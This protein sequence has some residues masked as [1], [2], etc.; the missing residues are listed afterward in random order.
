MPVLPTY[1]RRQ[2][3]GGGATASY[4]SEGPFTAPGR[5]MQGLGG[6]VAGLGDVIDAKAQ[7]TANSLGD[8]WFSKARAETAKE[9]A[10]IEQTQRMAATDGA[11]DH[12]AGMNEAYQ[13]VRNKWLG[14]APDPRAM[15]MYDEWSQ[16]YGAQVD[17]RALEFRA[18]SALATRGTDLAQTLIAH[19]QT[20]LADP[21][22][23]DETMKRLEDDLAGARQWMT[24]QQ[25]QE[26][27]T[28]AV[29][30][31]NIA[32]SQGD[33]ARDPKA[34]MARMGL[35]QTNIKVAPAQ[36]GGDTQTRGNRAM[37]FF[38]SRGYTK[39]Q[40]AG[41]VGNLVQESGVR[42]DGAVGDNGTAFG[43]AQWRGERFTRLKRFAAAQGKD[44]R[45]FDTQLAYI[46]MELQ[47]HETSAYK[48]LKSAKTVDEATAAFIGYER[49]R[50]WTGANP[51]GGHAYEK[52]L[53]NAA[54][55][56][57]GE[58]SYDMPGAGDFSKDP[59]FAGLDAGE[60]L[61]LYQSAAQASA[62]Q[63]K[64]AQAAL[65]NMQAQTEGA[66]KKGIALGD[67]S[68]TVQSILGSGLPDATQ[69][70]LINSLNEKNKKGLMA[71]DAL[72][73]ASAGGA[74]DRYDTEDKNGVGYAY[75]AVTNGKSIFDQDGA[76]FNALAYLYDR[77]RIVPK[78]AM[79]EIRAGLNS[80]DPKR[81][82]AAGSVAAYLAG[83]DAGA[84]SASEGGS[85]IA[86]AATTYKHLT[87]TLG[88]TADEAG[89]RMVDM[90]DPAK[91]REAK[92]LLESDKVKKKIENINAG[93]IG[94][95]F[96]T[97]YGANPKMGETAQAEAVMVGEYREIF[98][99]A[100]VES[101][102]DL[103]LAEKLADDRFSKLYAV[104]DFSTSGERT[105]TRMPPELAYPPSPVDGTHDYIRQQA[106]EA[107]GEEGIQ[108]SEV[109]LQAF[110]NTEPD[111]R[112]GRPPQ[113]RLYYREEGSD[114]LREFNLPFV[115]DYGLE[116]VRAESDRAQGIITSEQ[117]W[118]INKAAQEAGVERKDALDPVSRG[119]NALGILDPLR[120]AVG[121]ETAGEAKARTD[122]E[123]LREI[124]TK[125][126]RDKMTGAGN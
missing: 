26:F 70:T 44:W 79:N 11:V 52:R 113:Y 85:E 94:D 72:T 65:T 38:M 8:S 102:G 116:Q 56:A 118:E 76:A 89:Q 91:Q 24:P 97:W 98:R 104:T 14:Q 93:K 117:N 23:Y 101:A 34:F 32:K 57:G 120:R 64:A 100:V 29:K 12:Q 27:R 51:R 40:A 59:Q 96:D 28:E 78:A 88:M 122:K 83:V 55:F 53:A 108:A 49:P 109:Y 46:D 25:E 50:G 119:L 20:V 67:P 107:L 9:M 68:V 3:L 2:G 48:A 41:I 10:A 110:G 90:N 35:G 66:F 4:A 17:G 19:A 81:M 95:K 36:I 77:S 60:I 126:L 84:L 63:D 7:K 1:E 61:G 92:A 103:D 22:K 114:A 54:A 69:A 39:E 121:G 115:A 111:V 6:A 86:K 42:S 124:G 71:Q 106:I 62:A 37:S 43:M 125:K 80:A 18:A 87:E 123:T 5:A 47:K 82:A 33:I 30:Q 31:L 58:V 73:R 21:S 16:S 105:L 112:A 75:E 45:D 74:F 99:E 15:Q 13:G